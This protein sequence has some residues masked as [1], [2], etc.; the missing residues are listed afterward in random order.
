MNAPGLYDRRFI[1]GLAYSPS[2]FVFQKD[3]K[4]VIKL[5][6]PVRATILLVA[7]DSHIQTKK[8]YELIQ[9]ITTIYNLQVEILIIDNST[10]GYERDLNW[11]YFNDSHFNKSF[12]I[13]TRYIQ[14]KENIM[15]AASFNQA[16]NESDSDF[17]VFLCSKHSHVYH[18]DWLKYIIDC[19]LINHEDGRVLHG[20]CLVGNPNHYTDDISKN[21]H[22]Q[23]GICV[24]YTEAIRSFPY[25]NSCP[26]T[27]M[28]VERT[29]WYINNGYHL[30]HIPKLLCSPDNWDQTR[31]LSNLQNP[32]RYAVHSAHFNRYDR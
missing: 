20:G 27:G 15:L 1:D 30:I 13:R 32:I 14:N 2:N 12:G 17:I 9:S 7:H 22:V 24:E 6:D 18:K 31:H 29:I 8:L 4:P 21:T 26:H 3:S 25:P 10:R 5:H 11:S 23:G 16:T 19:M 28:D